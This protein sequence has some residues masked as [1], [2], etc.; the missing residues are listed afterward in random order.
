MFSFFYCKK[1]NIDFLVLYNSFFSFIYFF[2]KK[3]S[4]FF[5]ICFKMYSVI[6]IYNSLD[7]LFLVYPFFLKKNLNSLR[8]DIFRLFFDLNFFA[9]HRLRFS[10]LGYSVD[11][12]DYSLK[13]NV[14]LTQ[15]PIVQVPSFIYLIKSNKKKKKLLL[16]GFLSSS[17]NNFCSLLRSIKTCDV[18]K[19]KGIR[20]RFEKIKSKEG[21]RSGKR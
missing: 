20:L 8:N 6:K 12:F 19:H 10:G 13:L 21:K 16:K 7:I 17:L 1:L 9:K 4:L 3:N 15:P 5:I 18:Y 2:N 14:G 11:F